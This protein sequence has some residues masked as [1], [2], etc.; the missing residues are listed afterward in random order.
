MDALNSYTPAPVLV[1]IMTL[2]FFFY[3]ARPYLFLPDNKKLCH[4]ESERTSHIPQPGLSQA[5]SKESEFPEAWFV[6]NDIFELERRAIFSK[7]GPPP[8]TR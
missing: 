6:G 7:V 5:V 1:A 3:R 8:A 4:D 2:L